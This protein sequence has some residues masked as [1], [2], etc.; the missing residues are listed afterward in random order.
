MTIFRSFCL[1]S[2]VSTALLSTGCETAAPTTASTTQVSPAAA[3]AAA[4]DFPRESMKQLRI[5]MQ[6]EAVIQLVGK[7][8][9]ISQKD[10]EA[11]PLEVWT[12]INTLAPRYREV[13]VEMDETSYVDPITGIER[14]VLDPRQQME[15]IERREYFELTFDASNSLVDLNY[16]L[17]RSSEI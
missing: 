10:G 5:G 1:L 6:K 9:D 2:L 3:A 13:A 7:P 8:T 15:R 14:T 4:N 12:Y 16:D 17:V 11:G